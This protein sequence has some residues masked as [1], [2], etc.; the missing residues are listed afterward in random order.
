MFYTAFIFIVGVFFGQEYAIPSVK[1]ITLGIFNY[2][3]NYLQLHES[4]STKQENTY[5]Y[6]IIFTYTGFDFKTK[7]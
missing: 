3:K 6:D 5:I 7:K 1:I 4:K 2:T